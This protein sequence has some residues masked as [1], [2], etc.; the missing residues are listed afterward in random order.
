MII[1]GLHRDPWHDTGAALILDKANGP[2]I[3]SLSQERLDRVKDS[4]A[5]P[6]R[7]IAACMADSGVQ[8]IEEIDL[9]VLDYIRIPDWRCDEYRTPAARGTLLDR[10]APERIHVINHHLAHA[11]S[12]FY[13]SGYEDAAI[14]VVDGRGS[15]NETQSLFV[16]EGR[17]IRRI[18]HTDRIGIGLLYAAVTQAIGFGLLQEGKTMGLAPYGPD[19]PGTLLG[20]GKHYDGIV[21]DY[22]D[23][24]IEG[25]Y[26]L[27][28]PVQVESFAAK[29]HAAFEVQK[30]CE[31]ALL[32]LAAHAR[33]LTGKSRLC[34][35][36]GVALNSVANL[37]VLQ[38]GLFEEV[39]IN[40]AASD[41][42][43]PLGAA[44]YGHHVIAGKPRLKN[45]VSPFV[46]PL[47]SK[48]EI[49][50]AAAMAQD[51][52]RIERGEV[53]EKAADLLAA[54]CIVG[55]FHG[56]SEMGPRA[57]GNR[58]ILMSPAKAENKDVLN[59]RVK[60]REPF[61]PF[62]PA[63]LEDRA[64]E[65]FEIDRPSPYML[66]VPAVRRDKRAVIPA[67]THVDGTGR[68]QT[69][70]RADNARFHQLIGLF[71]A[72][73]DIPVLLNTS[74]NDNGE[75]IVES[76]QDAVRCFLSTDID[77][78][79]LEDVLLIKTRADA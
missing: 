14:L 21:T 1:L 70:S 62:A 11:C 34:L 78:L 40:P 43:I 73:T 36:G 31:E 56:R 16:G 58:S 74:F 22:A 23:R 8:S 71:A 18:E 42:G 19:G 26:D 77:A 29:A 20:L 57:L 68:L 25:S 4:R 2:H 6:A 41:T 46:G 15:D 9:V 66:L 72:R 10:I 51:R 79:V 63:C 27:R 28:E 37:V 53:L 52:C 69:V 67:V 48:Q 12:T 47:H 17:A 33:K 50:A 44:L 49:A 55:H 45:I 54:N 76:P 24:C 35:S 13:C 5:F 38:S 32:H 65:F 61:R 30:E 59:A 75:P 64:A 3:V 60:H 7:A 39:F